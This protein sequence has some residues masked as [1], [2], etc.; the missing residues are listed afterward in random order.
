MASYAIVRR[1]R[2]DGYRVDMVDDDGT[3]HTIL[4]FDTEADAQAWVEAEEKLVQFR[5]PP[6][7]E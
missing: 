3:R 1:R 5:T 6:D 7:A 4:G 2:Q